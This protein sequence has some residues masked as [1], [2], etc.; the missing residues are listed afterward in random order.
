MLESPQDRPPLA[1]ITKF[2]DMLTKME[3]AVTEYGRYIDFF[4]PFWVEGLGIVKK[5]LL[6][7]KTEELV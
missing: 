6:G 4:N 5:A 3:A 2:L 1:M 7:R